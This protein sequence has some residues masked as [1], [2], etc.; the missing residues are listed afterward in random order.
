MSIKS[1][2]YIYLR[3]Q[4][5]SVILEAKESNCLC[6]WQVDKPFCLSTTIYI[7]AYNDFGFSIISFS[8]CAMRLSNS[9]NAHAFSM[10]HIIYQ[11]NYSELCVY[12]DDLC[13]CKILIYCCQC[14]SILWLIIITC[15][16]V[17]VLHILGFLRTFSMIF[18]TISC[19]Y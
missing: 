13:S 7:A 8:D 5:H 2:I 16:P 15:V 12:V 1:Y 19:C 17:T 4:S 9:C 14:D 6:E 11:L 18:K 3:H 10:L